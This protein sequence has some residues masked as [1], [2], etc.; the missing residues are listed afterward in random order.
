MPA[1]RSRSARFAGAAAPVRAAVA[2]LSVAGLLA[3]ALPAG[4]ARA[5]PPSEPAAP[6]APER[7]VTDFYY[8]DT[9]RDPWRWM[10]NLGD[11]AVRDWLRV[12]GLH[13]SRVLA[14]MPQRQ[15]LRRVLDEAEAALPFTIE[16]PRRLPGGALVY[17]RRDRGA[18][19]YRLVFRAAPGAPETVLVDPDALE[20]RT[21][22]PHA[23]DWFVPA[24]DGRVVAYGLS[25]DGAENAAMHLIDTRT[26]RE[27]G[28]PVAGTARG[29]VSF[30]PDGRELWFARLPVAGP[31]AAPTDRY[32]GSRLWRLAV[33]APASAARLVPLPGD[34]ALDA[35]EV[36]PPAIR[37]PMLLMSE[38]GDAVARIADG[39]GD[40]LE[41]WHARLDDLRAGRPRW[42]RL[43]RREDGVVAF[44]F[45]R[46]RAWA[47]TEAGAPRRRLV[48]A[49]LARFDAASAPTVVA[50]GAR[51]L[52]GLAAAADG[53][54]LEA[55]E[56]PGKRLWRLDDA[57]ADGDADRPADA[58]AVALPAGRVFSLADA[59]ADRRLPGL[60][61]DLQGWTE[62]RRIF[63]IGADGAARDTGLQPAGPAPADV[64]ADDWLVPA[65]DGAP[66]PLTVLRRRDAPADG[67]NPAIVWAYGAYGETEEPMYSPS[68]LAWVAAGGVF[69]VANVRGGGY[70]G[71][72]WREAG[73][74]AGKPNSWRDLIACAEALVERGLTAPARL[75]VWGASAGGI[76][77][78][79]A[80]TERPG[81]FGAAVVSSGL[82]DMLRA[83]TAA[84]GVPNI[85][86]FGSVTTEA[87]Y[88]A[89]REMSPYEH[90]LPG[91][92]HPA[93]LLTA[94]INDPRVEPWHAA[95]MAARLRAADP[96]RDA[97]PVLLRI[98]WQGG[99]GGGSTRAQWLDERADVLGFFAWRLG[100][101]RLLR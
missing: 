44:V 49:P 31:D 89:L 98:D 66:V 100:G 5:E 14:A 74:G 83:E 52:L 6:H 34:E 94:G 61:L 75:G 87:G 59:H 41:L 63:E 18:N 88:R 42:R 79:R 53:V 32:R 33:G 4:P 81:L 1:R 80:F 29:D 58:L 96:E 73:Q 72:D 92:R 9:V 37:F 60:L 77:A 40:T 13:A 2:P 19:Q 24:P 3:I 23:I 17:L 68:R 67:G 55:R 97:A 27:L 12:E 15:R 20:R 57:L 93:V 54:Y 26:R 35:P 76:A 95:K 64:A 56:G 86:E 47:L 69:A 51:V 71:A 11:P 99:H 91:Q 10:E 16:A 46:G 82:L 62:P 30:S 43:A 85:A 101:L 39:A 8:G 90:V 65:A 21:G 22:R 28:A 48:A 78:G 50:E 38:D 70:Y 84:N 36:G 25:A 45:A 7:P